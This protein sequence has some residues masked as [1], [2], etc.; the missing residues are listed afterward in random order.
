VILFYYKFTAIENVILH[1]EF[2]RFVAEK[3]KAEGR[4]AQTEKG[5]IAYTLPL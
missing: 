2:V 5:V 4:L 1:N 3:R